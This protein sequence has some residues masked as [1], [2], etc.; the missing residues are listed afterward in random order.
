[1]AERISSLPTHT[2]NQ[3]KN[4]AITPKTIRTIDFSYLFL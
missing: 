2:I 3:A 4:P 1:M